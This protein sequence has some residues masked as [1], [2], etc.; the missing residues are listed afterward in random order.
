MTSNFII[1]NA[2][3]A[4]SGFLPIILII[5]IF[6][7]LLIRPQRQQQKKLQEQQSAMKAG[8][9]VVTAG[10]IHGIVR[11]IDEKTVKVEVSAGVLIKFEKSSIVGFASKEG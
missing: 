10:G 6:Y 9:K 3:E 1:A 4:I 5:V 11:D 7:F 2:Q 8:D